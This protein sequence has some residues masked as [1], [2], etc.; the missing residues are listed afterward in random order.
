MLSEPNPIFNLFTLTRGFSAKA[1]EPTI[2]LLPLKSTTVIL[3]PI[4]AQ[5]VIYLTDAGIINSP[6]KPV[7]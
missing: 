3:F 6:L 7:L 5:S 2:G 1:S 4:K